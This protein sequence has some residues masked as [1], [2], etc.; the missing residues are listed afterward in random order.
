MR[1]GSLTPVGKK[2]ERNDLVYDMVKNAISAELEAE[3]SNGWPDEGI[4]S[5]EFPLG[6]VKVFTGKD[7]VG[8]DYYLKCFVCGFNISRDD[9]NE[10]AAKA[11][12]IEKIFRHTNYG[13]LRPKVH[14]PLFRNCFGLWHGNT[15]VIP[16]LESFG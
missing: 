10:K 13:N 9:K 1:C 8:T 3:P 2:Q 11:A 12:A 14:D 5:S 15:L 4:P 16:P 6:V 7:S